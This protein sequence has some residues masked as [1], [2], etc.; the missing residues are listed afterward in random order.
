MTLLEKIAE[1]ATEQVIY[2]PARLYAKRIIH[3]KYKIKG[4]KEDF[5]T[6]IIYTSYKLVK[7]FQIIMSK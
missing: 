1:N 2:E 3:P 5:K 4:A 6:V 7:L